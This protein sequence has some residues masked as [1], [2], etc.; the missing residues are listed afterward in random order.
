MQT[1]ECTQGETRLAPLDASHCIVIDSLTGLF[2]TMRHTG[3][4]W[5][6]NAILNTISPVSDS[7]LKSHVYVDGKQGDGL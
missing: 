1:T 2:E 6:E 3:V 4:R 7:W 5:F